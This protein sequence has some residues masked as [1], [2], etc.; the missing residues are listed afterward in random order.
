M[1]VIDAYAAAVTFSDKHALATELARVVMRWERVPE[2]RFFGD[3]TAAFVHGL[4]PDALST[5]IGKSDSVRVQVTNHSEALDR[6]QQLGVVRDIT[7]AVASAATHPELAQCTGM[8]LAQA[9]P[10]GRGI[11]S[12]SFTDEEIVQHVRDLLGKQ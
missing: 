4:L 7:L 9:V 2:I 6:Q 10:G 8:V 12:D 3:D 1:P 11:G 5:A